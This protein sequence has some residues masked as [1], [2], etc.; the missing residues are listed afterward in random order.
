ML[1]H[2]IAQKP[3]HLSSIALYRSVSLQCH[4][5]YDVV[6][7]EGNLEMLQVVQGVFTHVQNAIACNVGKTTKNHEKNY[8][9]KYLNLMP[10]KKSS[11]G[12]I[13]IIFVL[14]NIYISRRFQCTV[15]LVAIRDS[16]REVA[17][18]PSSLLK[19]VNILILFIDL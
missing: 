18:S 17:L 12:R 7:S 2:S 8:F 4:Q 15:Q 14:K 5:A 3:P 6:G 1:T 16:Y 9:Y 19:C 11:S 10:M 13:L